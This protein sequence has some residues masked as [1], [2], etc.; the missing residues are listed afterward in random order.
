MVLAAAPAYA[1]TASALTAVADT[2]VPDP[3]LSAGL[4]AL[5]PRMRGLEATQAVQ[6]AEIA[7]LRRRSEALVRR[8]YERDVV[9]YAHSVAAVEGRVARVETAIR[10]AE[11][12]REEV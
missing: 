10:R 2:P 6:A 5:A 1:A 12:A 4:A 3:A 11:K 9:G 7:D 8:W